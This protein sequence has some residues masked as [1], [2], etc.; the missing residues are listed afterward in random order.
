MGRRLER[1]REI[2]RCPPRPDLFKKR[3]PCSLFGHSLH[4]AP[5]DGPERRH[6]YRKDQSGG[7]RRRPWVAPAPTPTS[8]QEVD[9]PRLDRLTLP[10]AGR[11]EEHTPVLQSLTHL[12]CRL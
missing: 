5:A 7:G 9:G 8:V 6:Q 1:L 11:S 3:L 12:L 4:P 2:V 10:V